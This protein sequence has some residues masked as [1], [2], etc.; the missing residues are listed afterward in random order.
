VVVAGIGIALIV[1]CVALLIGRLWESNSKRVWEPIAA[2]PSAIAA[3]PAKP[4]P[5][6]PPPTPRRAP[7]PRSRAAPTANRAAGY[8]SVNSS[9]WSEL[10]VDGHVV[11]STPQ[12]RIRVTPG[13]HHLLLVRDGFQTHSAWVIVPAGGTVRLTDITLPAVTR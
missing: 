5:P 2:A 13:R 3:E 9:P 12:V 8:L 1:T 10:S 4:T 11:G 6:P 7:P